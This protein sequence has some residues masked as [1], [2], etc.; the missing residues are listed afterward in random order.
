MQ[1]LGPEYASSG[2]VSGEALWMR[3]YRQEDSAAHATTRKWQS[4]VHAVQ[5]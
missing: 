1:Q 2:Q 3:F 4:L 5:Y